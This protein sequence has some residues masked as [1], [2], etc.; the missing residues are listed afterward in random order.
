MSRDVYIYSYL[1]SVKGEIVYLPFLNLGNSYINLS[2]DDDISSPAIELPSAI[3]LGDSSEKTAFVSKMI[4]NYY[5][6]IQNLCVLLMKY[7]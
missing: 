6:I 5:F 1:Y 7:F 2:N 3:P 4:I